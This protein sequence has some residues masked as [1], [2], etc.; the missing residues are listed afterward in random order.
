MEV[1]GSESPSTSGTS[2]P[3]MVEAGGAKSASGNRFVIII[4]NNNNNNNQQTTPEPEKPSWP[5]RAA[6][7][8]ES[9]WDPINLLWSGVRGSWTCCKQSQKEIKSKVGSLTYRY[10][11]RNWRS[12]KVAQNTNV[13]QALKLNAA[14]VVVYLEDKLAILLYLSVTKTKTSRTCATLECAIFC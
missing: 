1:D 7:R 12:F 10:F 4:N 6:S 2:T 3:A 11:N 13:V 5:E 9:K 8:R 14:L